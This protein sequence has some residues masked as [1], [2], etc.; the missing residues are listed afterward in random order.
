M[1]TGILR[2]VHY[3]HAA[4]TQLLDD[5]VVRNGLADHL[6]E[7]YGVW[8]GMSMY[9]LTAASRTPPWLLSGW[10]CRG[11]RLSSMGKDGAGAECRNRRN[12]FY[13][14]PWFCSAR[15]LFWHS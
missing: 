3:T 9:G 4:A 8:S 12:R 5:A 7:C 10:G 14:D 11:R 2:L 15:T 6:R 13:S 1:K